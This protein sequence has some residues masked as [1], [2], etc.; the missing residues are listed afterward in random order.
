MAADGI[1]DRPFRGDSVFSTLL[2][3]HNSTTLASLPLVAAGRFFPSLRICVEFARPPAASSR[4][5]HGVRT[6]GTPFAKDFIASGVSLWKAETSFT[7]LYPKFLT[8]NRPHQRPTVVVPQGRKPSGYLL[9]NSLELRF[10]FLALSVMGKNAADSP[11][12]KLAQGRKIASGAGG[13]ISRWIGSSNK[14]DGYDKMIEAGQ[15]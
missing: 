3:M 13:A 14:E 4:F 6:H 12:E 5:T 11:E 15:F 9:Q 2:V 7:W 10:P 1:G 8:T